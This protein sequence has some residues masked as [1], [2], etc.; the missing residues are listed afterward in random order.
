[1]ALRGSSPV[2]LSAL[3]RDY[4]ALPKIA[5]IKAQANQGIFNTIKK[6]IDDRNQKIKDADE[7]AA[8]I[9]V[10]EGIMDNPAFENVFGPNRPSAKDIYTVIG[11]EGIEKLGNLFS[12]LSKATTAFSNE[13]TRLNTEEGN[14]ILKFLTDAGTQAN[15]TVVIDS[16]VLTKAVDTLNVPVEKVIGFAKTILQNQDNK[17]RDLTEK[18]TKDNPEFREYLTALKNL[19]ADTKLSNDLIRDKGDFA[20]LAIP[21][22]AGAS[23]FTNW[24]MGHKEFSS[25][26]LFDLAS[27]PEFNQLIKENPEMILGAPKAVVDIITGISADEGLGETEVITLL[28]GTMIT[29]PKGTTQRGSGLSAGSKKPT[30]TPPT[31]TPQNTPSTKNELWED[32]YFQD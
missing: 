14:A 17:R 10:I 16:S 18:Y 22:I 27:I 3:Q 24:L 6:G 4:S 8:N 12:T 21:A 25:S 32:K 9:R 13:R 15:G 26:G 19:P 2:N 23:A 31:Q 7:K 29:V 1:M 30:Q 20:S 11:K 5:A 28:D